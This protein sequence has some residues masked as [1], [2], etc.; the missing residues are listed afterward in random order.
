MSPADGRSGGAPSPARPPVRIESEIGRLRAVAIH[1]PGP[2][3]E[4]MTPRTASEV[5]YN[6]IIPISVVSDEHRTL[7]AFLSTVAD[8]YEVTDLLAESLAAPGERERLVDGVCRTPVSRRR[9]GELLETDP[10]GLVSTLVSGLRTRPDTLTDVL[11]GREYDLP[12]LP[13][14][15]FM[16]D[17]SFVVRDRVVIGAMAHPVRSTEAMLLHSVFGSPA[18]LPSGGVIYDGC[19]EQSRSGSDADG[20]S[21]LR[22]EGGDVLVARADADAGRALL[23]VGVSERT[24]SAA[25][26]ALATRLLAAHDEPLTLVVAI[27]PRERSTIHLDMVFTLVDRDVALVYE[28]LVTGPRRMDAY[29]MRLEP[30]RAARVEK[31]DGLLDALAAEG[32]ALRTVPCGGADPVVRE[33]EQWLSAANAFAFAP[34]KIIG[35]DCNVATMESFSNAGFAVRDVDDYLAGGRDVAEDEKLFVGMPGINLA[36]GGGGPRCMTLPLVRDPVR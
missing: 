6:D 7:K 5:L 21:A 9:R 11:A 36:R 20:L 34:G 16:R 29:R 33:R 17:S 8:V 30:G 15:Y 3:I 35:Y 12:P 14:L 1:T 13:N 31:S 27:L 19:H 4:S 18:G 26:D 23:V 24:S 22:L 25:L 28:P 2:E 32:M 10:A